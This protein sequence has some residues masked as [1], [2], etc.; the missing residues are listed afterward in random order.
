MS[1]LLQVGVVQFLGPCVIRAFGHLWKEEELTHQLVTA[2]LITPNITGWRFLQWKVAEQNFGGKKKQNIK[3]AF[4]FALFIQ[5]V[6]DTQ[7]CLN[8]INAR[9]VVV[10]VYQCPRNPL[11][12]VLLLLQFEDMLEEVEEA[13]NDLRVRFDY[14]MNVLSRRKPI[15]G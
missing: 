14:K 1:I 13:E 6:E 11:F 8:E 7:L 15:P 5:K 12:H 4:Y 2:L 10:E 3:V 9:L